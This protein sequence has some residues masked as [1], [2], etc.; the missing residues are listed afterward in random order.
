MITC[1]PHLHFVLQIN[2]QCTPSYQYGIV[3]PTPYLEI[4]QEPKEYTKLFRHVLVT[5]KFNE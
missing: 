4:P 3:D 5:D 1:G 2:G